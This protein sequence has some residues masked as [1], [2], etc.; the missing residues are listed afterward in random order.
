MDV[1]K[2]SN[3]VA[4]TNTSRQVIWRLGAHHCSNLVLLSFITVQTFP[5]PTSVT[6]L[7]SFQIFVTDSYQSKLLEVI[8]SNVNCSCHINFFL[9]PWIPSSSA[10]MNTNNLSMAAICKVIFTLT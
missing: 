5:G 1:L 7:V 10:A 3:L 9:E 8:R 6:R 2:V 4:K